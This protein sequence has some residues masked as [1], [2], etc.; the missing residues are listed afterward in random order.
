[1]RRFFA[2]PLFALSLLCACVTPG[3]EAFQDYR[4]SYEAARVASTEVVEVYNQYDKANR[5][6]RTSDRSFDPNLADV[7]SETALTPIS[8]K[9]TEGF[10]AATVYIEVL[11]RYFDNN[12]LSLQDD[13]VARLNSAT[14]SVANLANAPAIGAQINALIAASKALVNLSLARD[15]RE[16]FKR[17][18]KQN[19][20]IVDNFLATVRADTTDMYRTARLATAASN[21]SMQKLSDFRVMLAHWVLLIDQ[22]RADLATLV[23]QVET[24]TGGQTALNLLAGSAERINA[25]T[26]EIAATRNALRGVF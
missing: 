10:A 1:M 16:E 15:D 9:I 12:T 26:Q 7:Y 5:R 17:S 6:L 20:D 4:V 13:D 21:G 11:G 3:G 19:S 24:G 25:Y 8:I 14:A 18:V 22:A 2:A 23:A